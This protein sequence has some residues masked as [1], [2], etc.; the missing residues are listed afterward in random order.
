[1]IMN[2]DELIWFTLIVMAYLCFHEYATAKYTEDNIY[3]MVYRVKV[4]NSS[5]IFSMHFH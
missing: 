3:N 2:G 4:F 5:T 1:M